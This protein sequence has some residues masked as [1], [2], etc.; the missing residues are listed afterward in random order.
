MSHQTLI[1]N[2][3]LCSYSRSPKGSPVRVKR[4]PQLEAYTKERRLRRT[5]FLNVK[6]RLACE[7]KLKHVNLKM[8]L[9]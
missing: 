8:F 5:R 9:P 4:K 7:M 1:R 2:V 3:L 6:E